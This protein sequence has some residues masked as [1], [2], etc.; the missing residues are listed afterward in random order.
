MGGRCRAVAPR[1][2]RHNLPGCRH[3]L[4]R[5]S[6]QRVPRSAVPPLAHRWRPHP[7]PTGVHP[8]TARRTCMARVTTC[9]VDSRLFTPTLEDLSHVVAPPCRAR[10]V[11]H[12]RAAPGRRAARLCRRRWALRSGGPDTAGGAG[13]RAGGA[14]HPAAVDQPLHRTGGRHLE[15]GEGRHRGALLRGARDAAPDHHERGQ[16]RAPG[17]HPARR[18]ARGRSPRRGAGRGR[19]RR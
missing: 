8:T 14:L 5:M 10:P 15:A 1:D 3:R 13:L 7:L 17:R 4:Q 9:P 6:S 12:L 2:G 11:D 16:P 19:R 18:P